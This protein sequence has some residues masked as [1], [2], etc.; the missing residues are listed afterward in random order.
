MILYIEIIVSYI[1]SYD[2]I[3]LDIVTTDEMQ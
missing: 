1:I 2:M 3:M